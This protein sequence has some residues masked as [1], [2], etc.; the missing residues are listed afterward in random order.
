MSDQVP[1]G[2]AQFGQSSCLR[3]KLLPPVLAKDAQAGSVCF[4][5]AFYGKRFAHAHQCDFVR[6]T[7]CPPRR[8][9][10]SLPHL[11]NIFR[12]RHKAKTTK[13]K[14]SRRRIPLGI[15]AIGGAELRTPCTARRD[16]TSHT[17]TDE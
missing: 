5:D 2:V 4:A 15:S 14:I 3:R 1:F 16:A 6:I 9:C 11:G 17:S 12:N 13:D 10:D 8:C 7:G